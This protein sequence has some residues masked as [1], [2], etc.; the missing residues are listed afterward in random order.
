M[1]VQ[2]EAAVEQ[3]LGDQQP[4]ARD[5]DRLRRQLELGGRPLGLEHGMPSRSA[6]AFAGGAASLR[7]RPAGRSGRVSS[8]ATSCRAASRSSTSA[9]NGAVAATTSFTHFSHN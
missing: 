9:P 6:D 7:P 4:V 3:R 1:H 8:A 2:P 5:D